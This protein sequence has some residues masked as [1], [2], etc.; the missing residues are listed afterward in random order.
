[1]FGVSNP[2]I[3]FGRQ[4]S[5]IFDNYGTNQSILINDYTNKQSP[6]FRVSFSFTKSLD[7]KSNWSTGN[8]QIYGLTLDTFNTLGDYLE[9]EVEVKVGYEYSSSRPLSKLFRAVLI[10]KS[11]EVQGGISVATFT[12][13]GYYFLAN[14][15]KS[16]S[17]ESV[18][19]TSTKLGII[20]DS[21][22]RVMDAI[23]K[24]ISNMGFKGYL[25][26]VSN[27]E[28]GF[29]KDYER[30]IE[31]V[32]NW[33]FPYGKTY[34]GTPKQVLEAFCTEYGMGFIINNND[35]IKFFFTPDGLNYHLNKLNGVDKDIAIDTFESTSIGVG[36]T[37]VISPSAGESVLL[38]SKTG[39]LG[40]PKIKTKTVT[41]SYN[42]AIEASEKI[43]QQKPVTIRKNKK[44]E[45][46][47]D[48]E[49]GKVKLK[50]PK[51]KKVLRRTVEARCLIN[52]VIEPQ[53]YVTIETDFDNEL[54]GDYRVR[55]VAIDGDT[56]SGGWVMNLSLEGEW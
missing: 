17:R 8:V 30:F 32:S 9:T 24:I 49:T 11:Y 14:F 27:V 42:A 15:V 45:A 39:L 54:N 51:N 53:S 31:Y 46:I 10:D 25:I 12:L 47:V 50:T 3:Q 44:G 18:N 16:D 6:K 1:M 5:I 19:K 7:E 21:T 22:H 29:P 52:T 41:K 28:K 56:E 37:K 40:L 2:D 23:D 26:D 48:K 55:T 38:N 13:Q 33:N 34:Y 4:C 43:Y 20:F 36:K 35:Y